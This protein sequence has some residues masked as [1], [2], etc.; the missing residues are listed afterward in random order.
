MHLSFEGKD[1]SDSSGRERSKEE[2]LQREINKGDQQLEQLN[3]GDISNLEKV[4]GRN[5][6]LMK[7][8]RI[9]GL[10]VNKFLKLQYFN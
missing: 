1:K 6:G 3:G 4:R 7:N 9:L 10:G 8:R 5:I 2:E